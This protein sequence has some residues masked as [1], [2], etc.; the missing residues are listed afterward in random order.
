MLDTRPALW[1]GL[2][3]VAVVA[4]WWMAT[5][6]P[7]DVD[8]RDTEFQPVPASPAPPAADKSLPEAPVPSKPAAAPAPPA[9]QAPESEQPE[10]VGSNLPQQQGPVDEL[11]RRFAGESRGH[12]SQHAEANARKAFTDPTIPPDMLRTIECR[13]SVCRAELRWSEQSN[14]GYVLGLTRAVGSY[15]AALGIAQPGEPEA[16]GRRSVVTYWSLAH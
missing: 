11:A 1:T 13:R 5:S 10:P 4:L 9:K 14:N 15:S 6:R 7:Q 16:D 12:D 8:V 3:A 2:L